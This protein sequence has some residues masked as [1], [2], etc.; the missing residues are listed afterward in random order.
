MRRPLGPVPLLRIAYVTFVTL[1][2]RGLG[3]VVAEN[4]INPATMPRFPS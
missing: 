2:R 3:E 4:A 1:V